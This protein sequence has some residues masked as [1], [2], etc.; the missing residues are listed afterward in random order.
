MPP[1]GARDA[2]AEILDP[3]EALATSR[4][5]QL[6]AVAAGDRDALAQLVGEFGDLVYGTIHRLTANGADAEDATQDVF[7][8]LPGVV[9]GFA[10][11]SDQFPGW[12]RRI[13]VRAALMRMRSGRRR[14]EVSVDAIVALVSRPDDVLA[15][16]TIEHA[17]ARLSD[18]HR[19]VFLLK[20]V[21]GY[22]HAEIAELLGISVANSEVR[23]HRARR[24]LRDL[25]RDSR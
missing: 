5:R 2:T 25:L 11:T 4:R 16:L 8:R 15:R 24:Q 22:D 13:A 6:D 9:S 18:E 17:L 10:G 7:I 23:L 3:D 12:L 20:E 14:H 1:L 21:E 19:T